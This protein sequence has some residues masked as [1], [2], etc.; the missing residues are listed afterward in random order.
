[1]CPVAEMLQV[2]FFLSFDLDDII[3]FYIVGIIDDPY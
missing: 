3:I 2:R 1:M